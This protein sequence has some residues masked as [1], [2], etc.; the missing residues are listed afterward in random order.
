[1]S[2][3]DAKLFDASMA[4]ATP[5][6]V[7]QAVSRAPVRTLSVDELKETESWDDGGGAWRCDKPTGAEALGEYL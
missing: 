5:T 7:P 2:S 6:V 1:M 3:P 4:P